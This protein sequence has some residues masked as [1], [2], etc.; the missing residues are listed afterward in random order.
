M[1]YISRVSRY[2]NSAYNVPRSL[3]RVTDGPPAAGLPPLPAAA[4]V[5]PGATPG[6]VGQGK[7]TSLIAITVPLLFMTIHHAIDFINRVCIHRYYIQNTFWRCWYKPPHVR[8]SLFR[9]GRKFIVLSNL[10]WF[11]RIFMYIL[12]NLFYYAL[13]LTKIFS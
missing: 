7:K 10:Y 8:L 12:Y 11:I 2:P 1:I 3:S 5:P 4:R 6:Q 13:S 9:G